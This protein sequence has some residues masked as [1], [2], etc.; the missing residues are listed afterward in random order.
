MPSPTQ[1]HRGAIVA[2]GGAE[3]KEGDRRLL[4]R[5]L[6]LCGPGD[7]RVAI[8]PTASRLADTGE[9]YS[10]LFRDL[11]ARTAPIVQVRDRRD[12]EREDWEAALEGVTGVFL[13]GGNQLRLSTILGGTAVATR[14]RRLNAAG[15][16]VA[17][18]SAGAAFVSEHMIAFG[19][20]GATP[21]AG[22]VSLAAGLGLT[23]RV[24]VDQHFRQR[25]RLGRLLAALSL[26]PFPV[27]LGIDEDTAAILGPDNV[28]EV[29]GAGAV[30]VVDLGQLD[31]S[32]AAYAEPGR[33]IQLVG[34]R[35]HVLSAGARF[36]L[37]GRAATVLDEGA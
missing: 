16:H 23:N 25:D 7:A 32:T 26:N 27:G 36:D 33:P 30:T 2:I 22:Q 12:V 35:V 20:E 34:A 29:A 13:T 5:F 31:A 4:K 8:V 19:A 17:G 24:I 28:V 18:T 9:R 37:E 1:N 10:A 11:G 15:V 14:I 3:D 21:L 6:N